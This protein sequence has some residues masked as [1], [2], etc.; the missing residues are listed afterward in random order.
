MQQE[1]QGLLIKWRDPFA[2]EEILYSNLPRD[3]QYFRRIEYPFNDDELVDIASLPYDERISKY[4]KIQKE[5]VE[6]EE[7]RM[8][9]GNGIY[10]SIN[11]VQTYIPASY[12]GYINHW[13][14]EH[15]EK[16]DYREA[17]R[18]FFLF[19]E[20]IC[21]ETEVL[22]VTR[23]KG[24][25]QGATSLGYYWQWWICGRLAEKRGGSISFNDDAA[26][27]NFTTMFMRGFKAMLPC[28]VRDFDSAAEKFVRFVKPIEK[29]KKGVIQKRQ[30]LNSYC[31]FLPNNI[32]AYDSGRLSFGL[33]DE[34]GKY[35]KM[36]VNT[37]WSKVSPTLKLGK[38]KVGFAYMPTTVNP[39]NKGGENYRQ[40]WNDADQNAINP[41]TKQPYGFNT[42]HKVV[43]YLVPAYE[44]YAGCI[45]KF[46][47]S[48]IEDPPQPIMGND[49]E[50]ITEGAKTIILKERALKNGEQRMEH[51]R[52][53][54][55]DQF[56]MFSFE[57][58]LCE[59]N[60]T[61][62][63]NQIRHLEDEPVFL[64]RCRLYRE[65]VTNKNIYNGRDETW[66][67]IKFMDDDAGEWL[68]YE[69]P[70]KEN[71]FDHHGIMKPL[72]EIR[73]SI[74][75]DTIKS[76][77]AINGSTATICVF[78]K[79]LLVHGEEKGLYPVAL[80]LGK[81]RLMNHLYE[82]VLK[83]CM[84]YG[85]K[86]NF[87]IDAGTAFYDYFLEKDSSPFLEWTPRIAIN[88]AQK[89]QRIKPGTESANPFQMAMELEVAKKYFDGTLVGGYNG[90]VH[91]IV[92]PIMLQQA[93][94]YNHSDRTK[95]DVI[96][97]LMMA[98]LPCFGSSDYIKEEE[99]RKTPL[100][101]QYKIK[102][103]S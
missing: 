16:P 56:D 4:N 83:A 10:A 3:E 8:T 22:A 81:P 68:L 13:T 102:I 36:N 43:R 35:D 80:Y 40:F 98:L 101:P 88:I 59:F 57:K 97:S 100:L 49:G 53:F 92:F 96:I 48:V 85:C 73:Y 12:W 17:D 37:Y 2:G 31:D 26:N 99:K 25:R 95:S 70:N 15:G 27:K 54:P 74:G 6:K 9:Y 93:L 60:E 33:F 84:W 58:G 75:V 30:G 11:G 34:S 71:N 72:N 52:D 20:Y 86:V 77:F 32:N 5:W 90:N 76:G 62:I 47:A 18:V 79:S 103:A 19:M 65:K 89:N 41:E 7:W 24:R 21:F 46:G 82:E 78:K 50:M 51:Q 87:E 44:G 67:E 42:K 39:K 23:G 61:R 55:L 64:R 69:V 66:E 1:I 63:I 94:E 38:K 91:R 28:F 14:L 45:D 29:A